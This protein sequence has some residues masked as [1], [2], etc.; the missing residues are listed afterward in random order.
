MEVQLPLL[1]FKVSD[2]LL[3]KVL[4]LH[5]VLG[6]VL[7]NYKKVLPTDGVILLG[8]IVEINDEFGNNGLKVFE[9]VEKHVGLVH[10][11]HQR[12]QLCHVESLLRVRLSK[13]LDL[14]VDVADLYIFA[15]TRCL[16]STELSLSLKAAVEGCELQ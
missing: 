4:V 5:I 12:N 15:F 7:H 16:L 9:L 2:N 14:L 10:L 3:P 6:G 1:I 8:H 11:A 13:M